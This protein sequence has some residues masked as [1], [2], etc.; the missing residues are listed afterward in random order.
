MSKTSVITKIQM[1]RYINDKEMSR[2]NS[3]IS[4]FRTVN[5]NQ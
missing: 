1:T 3:K 4:Y 2:I 5:N